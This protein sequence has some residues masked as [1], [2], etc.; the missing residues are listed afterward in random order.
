MKYREEY[1]VLLFGF[2]YLG[3][4]L[5]L[6]LTPSSFAAEDRPFRPGERLWG[7]FTSACVLS[8][9]LPAGIVRDIVGAI[10]LW[11]I[12]REYPKSATGHAGR[13]Y[14]I[15]INITLTAFKFIDFVYLRVPENAAHRVNV[16]GEPIE[17]GKSIRDASHWK[18]LKWAWDLFSTLRGVGWNWRV[19]NIE[20]VPRGTT[21]WFDGTNHSCFV[22]L[23]L[24]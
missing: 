1:S 12:Q 19:K 7:G 4:P 24:T 3:I 15:A 6:P 23:I 13:D 10:I 8:L 14:L 18:R 22:L 16:S 17:S 5:C 2:L 21:R 11:Y 20:D 9:L